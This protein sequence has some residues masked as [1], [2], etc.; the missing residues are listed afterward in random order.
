MR[1]ALSA[2]KLRPSYRRSVASASALRWPP[3]ITTA[4]APSF[5]N[6]RAASCRSDGF[7]IWIPTSISASGMFGVMMRTS[8]RI[9]ARSAA[10][11]VLL[12]RRV[13][14]DE[15]STGSTTGAASLYSRIDVATALTIRCVSQRADFHRVGFPL[16]P[17]CFDLRGNHRSVQ[18]RDAQH[19]GTILRDDCG[20]RRKTIHIECG[21]CFQVR[22]NSRAPAR[23]ASRNGQRG[24]TI[25]LLRSHWRHLARLHF[26]QAYAKR[27]TGICEE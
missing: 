15:M 5:T 3:L 26:N 7:L 19:L 4:R 25:C 9:C 1:S 17:D 24:R 27:R 12:R 8:G 20:D 6:R 22:L 21:E 13:P 18:R 11:P 23:V 2:T 14:E 16:A 10:S